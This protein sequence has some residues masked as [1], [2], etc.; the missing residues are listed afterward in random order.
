MVQPI[1]T[2]R[3]NVRPLS[4]SKSHHPKLKTRGQRN[5]K[6]F[7]DSDYSRDRD[8]RR[9]VRGFIAYVDYAHVLLKYKA[10]AANVAVS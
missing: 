6:A 2:A 3:R 8:T 4:H 1:R 5:I 10:N 7:S 9:S